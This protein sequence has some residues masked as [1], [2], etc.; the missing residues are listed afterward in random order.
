MQLFH[1]FNIDLV[2]F[3]VLEANPSLAFT[4]SVVDVGN[5]SIVP[6]SA[7]FESTCVAG[8]CLFQSCRSWNTDSTKRNDFVIVP[9]STNF[10]FNF[11]R[12]FDFQ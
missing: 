2:A 4:W 11:E 10:R 8:T 9:S 7:T 1:V 3:H 6:A 5:D 12:W